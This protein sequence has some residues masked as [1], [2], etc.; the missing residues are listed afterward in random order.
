MA[1]YEDY[2]QKQDALSEEISDA[3]EQAQDRQAENPGLPDRFKDKSPEEIAA[4]YI[5]LEKAYSRQGNDLGEMRKTLDSY[6]TT[7]QSETEAS[8]EPSST[9]EPV[10]VDDLY[11]DT[12]GAIARAVEASPTNDRI[13]KLE[14]ELAQAKLKESLSDLNDK[15]EGWQ[16]KVQSPEFQNWA[17]ES[18]YR[19]RL[20]QAADR[21]DLEAAEEVLGLYYERTSAADLAAEAARDQA[22]QDASLESGGPEHYDPETRY[23]RSDLMQKRVAAMQG[24]AEAAAYLKAHSDS[25]AFAYEDNRIDD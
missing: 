14:E 12:Q 5:E 16:D 18:P 10:T 17:A 22:L 20:V 4:S 24:D 23:S 25:I 6:I 21:W 8:Q 19:M 15:F 1:K 7:L 2:V 13:A 11:D 9:A 3:A